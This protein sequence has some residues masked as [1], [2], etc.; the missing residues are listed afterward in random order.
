MNNH[1]HFSLFIPCASIAFWPFQCSVWSNFQCWSDEEFV[2]R[3]KNPHAH[4]DIERESAQLMERVPMAMLTVLVRMLL[5]MLLLLSRSE[6][7]RCWIPNRFSE[8]AK[9]E[10]CT[11]HK[12]LALTSLYGRSAFNWPC[13]SLNVFLLH[14]Q[15]HN[16]RSLEHASFSVC[17]HPQFNCVAR[18]IVLFG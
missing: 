17:S 8:C 15:I 3:N 9:R 12:Y 16:H 13:F 2:V 5:L 10:I 18:Y 11:A 4:I 7:F 1:S 14:G 6:N